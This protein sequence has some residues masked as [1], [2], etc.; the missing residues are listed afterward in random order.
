LLKQLSAFPLLDIEAAIKTRT[1]NRN[2]VMGLRKS[3][4]VA[5]M[6][7]VNPSN[8]LVQ[9]IKHSTYITAHTINVQLLPVQRR[10]HKQAF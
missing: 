4:T 8:N 2:F 6:I 10:S 9:T 5:S 7:C 3:G 1:R